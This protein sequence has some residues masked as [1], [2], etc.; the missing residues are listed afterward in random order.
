MRDPPISVAGVV[1]EMHAHGRVLMRAVWV[2]GI[3]DD[4]H[5]RQWIAPHPPEIDRVVMTSA[6]ERVVWTGFNALVG[7]IDQGQGSFEAAML[8]SLVTRRSPHDLDS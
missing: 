4:M 5:K 6:G 8:W 7:V 2:Q 1:G 3:F